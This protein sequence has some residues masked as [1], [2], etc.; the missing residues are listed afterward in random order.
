M[1]NYA[2]TIKCNVK[3]SFTY[4]DDFNVI[5]DDMRQKWHGQFMKISY[6]L[7][8]NKILH[9]HALLHA[10]KGIRYT[11][12]KFKGWHIFIRV[13]HDNL[14]RWVEYINKDPRDYDQLIMERQVAWIKASNNFL[15]FDN[16]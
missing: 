4:R 8:E 1:Q 16:I 6:E 2:V 15:D 13:I 12:V 7:D 14:K 9:A 5:F 10:K 3:G 11:D